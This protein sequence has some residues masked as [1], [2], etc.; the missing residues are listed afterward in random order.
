[1][2]SSLKPLLA[3]LSI[4]IDRS[5]ANHEASLEALPSAAPVHLR[6]AEGSGSVAV[7]ARLYRAGLTPV[8]H[9]RPRF[10]ARRG[11]LSD[12]LDALTCE[13]AVTQLVLVDDD[14]APHG[15]FGSAKEAIG[16]G[17][18]CKH[19]IE[20]IGLS[21]LGMHAGHWDEMRASIAQAHALGHEAFVL[22]PLTLDEERLLAWCVRARA[23][24]GEIAV[25]ASISAPVRLGTLLRSAS[26]FDLVDHFR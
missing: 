1:M 14:S 26:D 2:D 4:E 15:A 19:G 16:S 25:A 22:T 3:R 10:F 12:L 24:F 17:L 11:E 13:A 6:N 5:D 7:C 9:L 18:F 8:P 20:S 23:E 21:R